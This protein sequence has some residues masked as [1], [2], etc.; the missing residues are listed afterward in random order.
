MKHPVS[1][2]SRQRDEAP[3][4]NDG[5][6]AAHPDGT[7]SGHNVVADLG[8]VVETCRLFLVQLENRGSGR[9]TAGDEGFAASRIAGE[10]LPLNEIHN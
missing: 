5:V 7:F 2:P 3:G 4:A 9:A 10:Q 8:T 6:A 1:G